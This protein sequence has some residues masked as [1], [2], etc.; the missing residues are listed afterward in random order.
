MS[1]D[2]A[3]VRRALDNMRETM[4]CTTADLVEALAT[5]CVEDAVVAEL[6]AEA[7]AA[8]PTLAKT[9]AVR[10]HEARTLGQTL[11]LMRRAK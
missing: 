3:A 10:A 7:V 1:V 11:A 2:I 4:P 5:L 9:Y 6:E 8:S